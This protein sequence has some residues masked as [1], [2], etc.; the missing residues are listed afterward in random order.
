MT[1]NQ[2]K[3]SKTDKELKAAPALYFNGVFLFFG[4][5]DIETIAELNGQSYQWRKVGKIN[6]VRRNHGVIRIGNAVFVVG[7]DGYSLT[8]LLLFVSSFNS[9]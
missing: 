8:V 3:Y 4:G 7:G 1:D 5:L 9:E 2:F 6:T